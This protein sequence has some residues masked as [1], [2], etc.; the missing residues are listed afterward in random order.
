MIVELTGTSPLSV[1]LPSQRDNKERRFFYADFSD[2]ATALFVRDKLSGHVLHGH[3]LQAEISNP[4]LKKVKDL[5][6]A[7]RQIH[8]HNLNFKQTTELTLRHF[9]LDWGQVAS[10]H[11]P[12]SDVSKTKGFL[13]NGFAFIT[14]ATESDASKALAK[15]KAKIDDRIIDISAVK[16]KKSVDKKVPDFDDQKTVTIK[17]V[18]ETVTEAQLRKL[19]EEQVGPVSQISLKPS[20]KMALI[21]FQV[22]QDAGKAGFTLERFAYEGLLLHVGLKKDFFQEVTAK[23]PT[24]MSPMLMRKR[25]R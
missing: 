13:N 19:V 7:S 5:A 3:E 25:R 8:L 20:K 18:A 23:V 1:R 6:P 16:T 21:E 11:L 10:V 9:F 12:L 24:M 17:N 14:F 4:T 15:G 22:T 2:E